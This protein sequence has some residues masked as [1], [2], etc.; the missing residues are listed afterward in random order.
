MA[1][2]KDFYQKKYD[3]L[4]YLKNDLGLIIL[5]ADRLAAYELKVADNPDTAAMV[6]LIK[7]MTAAKMSLDFSLA[8]VERMMH[9]KEM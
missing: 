7:K 6:K 1:Q 9:E 5:H 2:P 4:V 3:W 8:N